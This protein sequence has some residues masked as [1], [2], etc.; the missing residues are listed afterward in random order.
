MQNWKRRDQNMCKFPNPLKNEAKQ[1]LHRNVFPGGLGNTFC[2]NLESPNSPLKTIQ[3]STNR[4]IEESGF[5]HLAVFGQKSV[6]KTR[7]IGTGDSTSFWRVIFGHLQG[8]LNHGLSRHHHGV[9]TENCHHGAFRMSRMLP[10]EWCLSLLRS[11]A[12]LQEQGYNE[13]QHSRAHV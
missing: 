12:P 3:R 1:A 5:S 2:S 13:H 6:R 9:V 7:Q 4:L 11:C 10:W 8:S